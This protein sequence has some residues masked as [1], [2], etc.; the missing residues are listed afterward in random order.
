MQ[1]QILT[2]S[3]GI[4]ISDERCIFITHLILDRAQNSADILIEDAIEISK[5]LNTVSSTPRYSSIMW[6]LL[7]RIH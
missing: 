2:L 1:S 6:N 4:D 7:L 3:N 5:Q